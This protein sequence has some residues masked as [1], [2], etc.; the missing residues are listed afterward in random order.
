[1]NAKKIVS[2]VGTFLMLV[3]LGFI[4]RRLATYGIDFSL[5]TSPAVVAGLL[6]VAFAEGVVIF[7]ASF[8]FRALLKNVSGISVAKPVAVVVY[9]MSNLYKY[10]PGGIMYVAGR[11][12]MAVETE[13]LRHSK[14]AFSTVA[15]GVIT[16]LGALVVALTL[17]FEHSRSYVLQE[18]D[19]LPFVLLIAGIA[20]IVIV[21][22][23][24]FFREKITKGFKKFWET[25]E[26][27]KPAVLAKRFAWALAMMFLWGATFVITL[28]LLGQPM[29][30]GLV[31]TIIGLYLLAWLAGFLTPGAPS[32]LGIREAVMMM[33]LSGLVYENILLAA[34][35][36]H[37][38]ITVV[39][40]LAAYGLGLAYAQIIKEEL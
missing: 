25:V 17:A 8:N 12:R 34:M 13:G 28:V 23:I 26:I 29:T 31:T 20:L 11:H 6:A 3:S 22:P 30:D 40:D 18:F 21:P 39:G 37:R 24:Y 10:I 7:G 33:F 4:A 38:V 5:L 35:V 19:F 1:M 15:E 27:F 2:W 9:L 16:A 14:V 36:I 32:G